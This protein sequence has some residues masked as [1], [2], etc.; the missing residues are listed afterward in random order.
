MDLETSKIIQENVERIRNERIQ[1]VIGDLMEMEQQ[2]SK[3]Y[4]LDI[5]TVETLD[6]VK[7][8][9]AGLDLA[10]NDDDPNFSVYKKYFTIEGE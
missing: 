1:E 3:K 4:H 7:L 9:L 10:I 5:T 6:D 2:T 8:I